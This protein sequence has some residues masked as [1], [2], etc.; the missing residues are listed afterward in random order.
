MII[1]GRRINLRDMQPSDIPHYVGW[2]QIGHEWQRYDGPYYEHTPPS[3]EDIARM[4]SRAQSAAWPQPRTRLCIAERESDL[5][6]GMVTWYWISKETNWPA[7][8][9]AI[10]DPANWSKGIGY[11]AL[12]LWSDYLFATDLNFARLDLRTW[13]G[14]PGMMKLAQKLGFQQEACF[15]KARIVDGDYYDGMGYGILREEWT[16]RYPAGFGVS[17]SG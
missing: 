16:A 10:F 9:I 11:E 2:M 3:A 8:G 5:L 1:Q 6:L 12:G 7:I 13:S 17:L 15:R 4:Q 14:N